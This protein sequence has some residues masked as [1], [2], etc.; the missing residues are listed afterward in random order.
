MKIAF[1][2]HSFHLKTL[3]NAFFVELLRK[4]GEVDVLMDPSWQGESKPSWADD[5]RQDDYDCIVVYQSHPVFS[6]LDL[7]HPNVIFVPMYDAMVSEGSVW[8]RQEFNAA[9][10]LCFSSTLY[11]EIAAF[12]L[13][14][15]YAR[16]F[17]DP[18]KLPYPAR[19]SRLDAFFW[20]R[21]APITCELLSRLTA[22][23]RF[24]RLTLHDAPDPVGAGPQPGSLEPQADERVVTSWFPDR[25]SYLS[26][27]AERTV[28]FASRLREGIGVSFLEAMAMGLCVVAPATATHTEYISHGTN[29]LLY[30]P[31]DAVPV[32]LAGYAALG[33]RARES[34]ER[35]RVLWDRNEAALLEFISTPRE[36]LAKRPAVIDFWRRAQTAP[37][38]PQRQSVPRVT[39]VTVCLNA[40]SEIEP[41]LDSVAEQDYPALEYLVWDGGSTDGTIAIL[42]RRASEIDHWEVRPHMRIF[43]AMADALARANGEY[44]LYLNA[45]DR[46]A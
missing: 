19:A 40:A 23:T 12:D 7:A 44:V 5:F 16:Y 17:P 15:H 22:G 4:C 25:E 42:E 26:M 34:V 39:V 18:A 31:D 33:A 43:S 14:S 28:Y 38:P 37:A 2:G 1:L 13:V 11:R 45:G 21:Q 20:Y 8:W 36:R 3:S 35:G 24:D 10:V 30:S 9:K 41:T 32:S 27:L 29:G 6:L 46:F